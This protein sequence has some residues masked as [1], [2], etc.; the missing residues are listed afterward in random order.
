MKKI[1]YNIVLLLF[2]IIFFSSCNE[3]LDTKPTAIYDEATVFGS[4]IS[5]QAF[6]YDVYNNV[7]PNYVEGQITTWECRTPNMINKVQDNQSENGFNQELITNGDDLGFFGG[8]GTIR[9][10]NMIIQKAKEYENKGLTETDTKELM[11]EGK[12]LRALYYYRQARGVGRIVY[13]DKVLTFQD[14]VNNGLKTEFKL[15]ANPDES[16]KLIIKD[17]EEAIPNMTESKTPGQLNKGAA[18][19]LLSEVCL[20]AAAYTGDEALR[21]TWL[22]KCIKAV[23]D[24]EGLGYSLVGA[25]Q[26]GNMFNENV[27]GTL[28]EVIFAH[29]KSR[30]TGFTCQSTNMQTTIPNASN[31][32]INDAYAKTLVG[33][34][35][36]AALMKKFIEK[37]NFS[38]TT[39]FEAWGTRYPT[40]NLADAYLMID[41]DGTAKVWHQTNIMTSATIDTIY[42]VSDGFIV[43]Q[44]SWWG[45]DIILEKMQSGT[46]TMG[47]KARTPGTN[48]S[49]L[50]YS[51]RDKRFYATFVHDSSEWYKE[52]VYTRFR[53]N[54]D[55]YSAGGT[56][57]GYY[58]SPS[59]YYLR[60]QCYNNPE[61]GR[62]FVSNLTDYHW[63]LF[64]FGRALL[65]KAEALLWKGQYTNAVATLNRT[66]TTHGDLPASTASGSRDAWEDYITERRAE[67]AYENDYYWSCL[68]WGL[69]GGDANK[70]TPA[71]GK[72]EH[73][74][75][76]PTFIQISNNT[77]AF[78]VGVIS[79]QDVH[80]RQFEFNNRR[81]LLP[82]PK[83]ELEKNPNLGLQNPGW[84]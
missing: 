77:D 23:D 38:V 69:H 4:R 81:Y 34:S 20:T 18:Y 61:G 68:R 60:K 11:A 31:F 79:F 33:K 72:A 14:T 74:L 80:K 9:K 52:K 6:V 29:Y 15:T 84:E 7:I 22:D 82:I 43:G 8:Y 64:R 58:R 78:F 24:L 73:L 75:E 53:G 49:A 12:L 36:S 59:N 30:A 35:D 67:L 51:N 57:L 48:L 16:Y 42:T 46:I 17:I 1:K 2:G 40:Q 55:R 76:E 41:N 10:I 65:N 83:K 39:V 26:F 3:V 44:N 21:T 70:D 47:K 13:I 62:A 28:N 45:K 54:L 56:D 25:D 32:Q 50:M 27:G 37:Y 19:A 5:A 71:K 66:R 63:V